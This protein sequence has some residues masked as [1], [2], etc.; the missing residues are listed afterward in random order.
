MGGASWNDIGASISPGYNG[1]L[2]TGANNPL[3]GRPAFVGA[4][5]GYPTLQTAS[6]I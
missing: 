3:E 6:A 4:S 5:A 1:T 2:T